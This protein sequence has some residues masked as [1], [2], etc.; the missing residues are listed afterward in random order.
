MADEISLHPETSHAVSLASSVSGS[1]HGL[2]VDLLQDISRRLAFISIVVV[3]VSIANL[4]VA[5]LT[6]TVGSRALRYGMLA[7]VVGV[8]TAVLYLSRGGR[9]APA[10]L[11][12]IGLG[13][14]VVVALMASQTIISEIGV[15]PPLTWSSVAV[16]VLIYPVI[17]PNTI[18]RTAVASVAAAATEPLTVLLYAAAGSI[19]MPPMRRRLRS[20]SRCPAVGRAP[21]FRYEIHTTPLR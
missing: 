3:V 5:E 21:L 9:V 10:R 1:K 15:R 7:L 6:Q 14:E 17:V 13:Y 8:S 11:L 19:A 4:V 18:V 12:D 16:W 20:P 2:P